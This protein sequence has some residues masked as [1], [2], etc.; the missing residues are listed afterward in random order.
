MTTVS[1]SIGFDGDQPVVL[2]CSGVSPR[3]VRLASSNI[4]GLSPYSVA[5]LSRADSA[6]GTSPG[7]DTAKSARKLIKAER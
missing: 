3:N 2:G 4:E 7:L 5:I 6:V 1:I